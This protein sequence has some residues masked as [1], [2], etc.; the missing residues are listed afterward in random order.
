MLATDADETVPSRADRLLAPDV[1][2]DV[3]PV[4]EVILNLLRALGV[5]VAQVV[6]RLIGEHHAP[7]ERDPCWVALEHGDVMV[8]IA[9]LHRSSEI[10]TCGSTAYANDLHVL[11]LPT[12]LLGQRKLIL[13]LRLLWLQADRAQ[14]TLSH[15]PTCLPSGKTRSF[16][17]SP[18]SPTPSTRT[19]PRSTL[20]VYPPS[21]PFGLVRP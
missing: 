12:A 3:V 19:P 8:R 21:P 2:L 15:V 9:Q 5:V 17:V 7:T 1:H 18:R 16:P 14:G 4:G 10:Q 11:P 6:E 13:S 20:A